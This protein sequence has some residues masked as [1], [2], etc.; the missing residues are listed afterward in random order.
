MPVLVV[1]DSD[2]G[3]VRKQLFSLLPRY[4]RGRRAGDEG[5]GKDVAQRYRSV[6]DNAMHWAFRGGVSHCGVFLDCIFDFLRIVFGL[7]AGESDCVGTSMPGASRHGAAPFR[8]RPPADGVPGGTYNRMIRGR[9]S[10][11]KGPIA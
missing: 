11:A 8:D 1:S 7:F 5:A 6:R 3:H 2:L 10:S 9:Q 4:F